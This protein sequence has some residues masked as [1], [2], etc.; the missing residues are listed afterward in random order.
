MWHLDR[1]IDQVIAR[2][3]AGQH[4]VVTRVQL[5]AAGITPQEI[6]RR[7]RRGNLIRVHP[8]VYRVGHAA[9]SV[10]ATYA[11]AVLGCGTGALLCG[12][13]A[14]WLL[15]IVKGRAPSPSVLCPTE[16]RLAGVRTHRQR[17]LGDED[18]WTWRG[19]PCTSPARTLVDLAASLSLDDLALA[20]HHAGALHRT[21]PGQVRE[22]LERRPN[23]TGA[24]KAIAVVEGAP[25]TLSRLERLFLRRLREAGLP[26]PDQVNRRVGA[27]RIDCRWIR[28]RVTVE[29][30]SYRWHNSRHSWEQDR[31]RERAAYARGDRAHRRYTWHDVAEAPAPMLAELRPLLLT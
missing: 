24:R 14:A 4:G 23:S 15:G 17:G 19:I 18:R 5:L 3:A 2:L 16:R 1:T 11:A 30:D 7:V 13:A 8:G 6:R 10:E 21:T 26:Q 12:P 25:V 31:R 29:L 28:Q 27:H 20:A 22:V 9:P